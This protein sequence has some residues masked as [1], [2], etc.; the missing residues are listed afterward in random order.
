MSGRSSEGRRSIV[1]SEKG[2]GDGTYPGGISFR[3]AK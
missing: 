1:C 2:T 3:L